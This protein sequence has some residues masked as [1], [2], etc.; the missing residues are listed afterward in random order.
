MAR[1]QRGM[2]ESKT[3]P[4][5]GMDSRFTHARGAFY[6]YA[7]TDDQRIERLYFTYVGA[8]RKGQS[9]ISWIC[10]R[11]LCSPLITD[12][13]ANITVKPICPLAGNSAHLGRRHISKYLPRPDKNLY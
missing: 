10:D 1:L 12:F 8:C 3:K 4:L 5:A 6:H 11:E 9:Q 7:T 13:A 2:A